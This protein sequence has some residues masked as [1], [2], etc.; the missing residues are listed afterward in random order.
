MAGRFAA[1]FPRSRVERSRERCSSRK[2]ETPM[3]RCRGLVALFVIVLCTASV[4]RGDVVLDAG[5]HELVISKPTQTFTI[6]AIGGDAVAGFVL[7]LQIGDGTSGP[8]FTSVDLETGTIFDGNSGGQT[9]H[10]IE[11]HA[12]YVDVIT[13][14]GS[15][16]ADGVVA[17]VTVDTRGLSVGSYDLLLG[18][19]EL[20]GF[21]VESEFF[22]ASAET[23]PVTTVAGTLTLVPEPTA[24]VLLLGGAA[25]VGMVRRRG[26][27]A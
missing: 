5:E 22:D 2:R 10:A 17:T 24:G 3:S 9:N 4:G 20:N 19:F 27:R 16:A 18:G 11:D 23:V 8:I 15:V 7:A 1:G 26:R 25:V 14:S 12:L 6:S 13:D 21:A